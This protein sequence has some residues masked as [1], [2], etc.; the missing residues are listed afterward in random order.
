VFGA[1]ARETWNAVFGRITRRKFVV[2]TAPFGYNEPNSVMGGGYSL[3]PQP[4]LDTT[5]QIGVYGHTRGHVGSLFLVLV[6]QI[7]LQLLNQPQISYVIV[8]EG[9]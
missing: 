8:E 9:R 1:W 7:M 3:Y 4:L 6:T 5:S 2:S